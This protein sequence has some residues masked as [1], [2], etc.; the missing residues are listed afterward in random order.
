VKA[1]RSGE[2]IACDSCAVRGKGMPK[3]KAVYC[4]GPRRRRCRRRASDGERN[5]VV[6]PRPRIPVGADR[7]AGIGGPA[8]CAG[9]FEE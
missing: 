5:G 1:A 9:K 7:A 2:R 8:S 4:F 6:P 3:R